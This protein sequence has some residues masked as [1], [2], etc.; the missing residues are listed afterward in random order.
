MC[1]SQ[2][3]AKTRVQ[4]CAVGARRTECD[5]TCGE[6]S[7]KTGSVGKVA[8]MQCYAGQTVRMMQGMEAGY[9]HD[10]WRPTGQV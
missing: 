7:K 10:E 8:F 4:N 9:E 2:L 5:R 6:N 1:S 3:A